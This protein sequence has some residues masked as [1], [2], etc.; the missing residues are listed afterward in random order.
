MSATIKSAL[1]NGTEKLTD[2]AV[3]EAQND[4]RLLLMHVLG[5]DRAFLIAH[6][7]Q[8]LRADQFDKFIALVARRAAG[9]PLQYLTGHQQFFKHDF[10]V[11]PEVLIPR[12]ETEL[13]VEAAL[14]LASGASELR[15]ADIGTGSGCL[16]ISLLCEWPQASALGLD[17]SPGALKVARRNAVRHGVADRFDLSESDGFK[18]IADAERFGLIVSN[19]PYVSDAEMET[20]QREVRREPTVALAGGPD[21]FS[22]IRR[23]LQ[24]APS[25][26]ETGGHFI[27]EIGFGQGQAVIDLID[28]QIWELIEIRPDLANVPRTVVLRQK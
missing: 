26:L 14:E 2:G 6:P 24:E 15:L 7:E 27:F 8:T 9:E 20:L 13:I 5:R 11:T 12:P 17:V 25:H 16:A 4:S 28:E 22:V 21:G 23:L 10:E 1:E 18:R 19:P 3:S